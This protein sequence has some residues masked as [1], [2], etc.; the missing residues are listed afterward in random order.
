MGFPS[1]AADHTENRISIDELCIDH[2]SSTYFIRAGR[3]APRI[4]LVRG[5]L[6]VVDS[7]LRP[8]HGS[9]IVSGI[10]EELTVMRYL[11]HPVPSLQDLHN[12]A[13]VTPIEDDNGTEYGGGR[14]AIWG[15]VTYWITPA[16]MDNRED[17]F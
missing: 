10:D 11:L 4:G 16:D 5:A 14:Q 1:P 7:S 8:K 3:H 9:I 13:K 6:L 15:V 12:P 2:P 17:V